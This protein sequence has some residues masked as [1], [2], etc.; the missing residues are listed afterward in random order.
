MIV[1]DP[2]ELLL[3]IEKYLSEDETGYI[4]VREDDDEEE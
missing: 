4:Q 2:D 1:I 3:A